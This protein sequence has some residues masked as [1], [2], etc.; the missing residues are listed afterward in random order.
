MLAAPDVEKPFPDSEI[1]VP[2]TR[3]FLSVVRERSERSPCSHMS[4]YSRMAAFE[5]ILD[6]QISWV[7]VQNSNPVYP[8]AQ[9]P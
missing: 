5:N 3:L 1:F 7:G 9:I 8:S 2:Y 6:V 4:D